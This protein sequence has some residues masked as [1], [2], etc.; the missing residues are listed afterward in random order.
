MPDIDTMKTSNYLKK[1]DVGQGTPVIIREVI[2]G[3]IAQEGKPVDLKWLIYFNEFPKPLVSNVTHREQIAAYL[4]SRNSDHWLGKSI[5]LFNDPS[6]IFNGNIGGIRVR[7]NQQLNGQP[8]IQQ[9]NHPFNNPVQQ[10]YP[11][12]QPNNQQPNN[13]QSQ[14]FTPEFDDD[15]P[16]FD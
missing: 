5:V 7:P 16:G 12:Q 1:E 4:G 9:S 2:E 3:N 14:G 11:N 13:Q 8:P 6:V 15:I 10:G